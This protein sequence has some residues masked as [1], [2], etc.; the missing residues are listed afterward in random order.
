M[1]KLIFMPVDGSEVSNHAAEEGFRLAKALGSETVLQYVIDIS[2]VTLP[3]AEL[4]ISNLDIIRESF[5]EQGD[6]VLK[7]LSG[8]AREMGVP[9]STMMTEGDVHDEIINAAEEKKADLIVLGTHGRRGLNRLI[10][11]SV[12]GSVAKRAHC[13]VLLIRPT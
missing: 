3:D 2:I 9:C 7:E 1:Y 6:K 8:K 12:A 4:A 5:R 11:G 10:L 13:P